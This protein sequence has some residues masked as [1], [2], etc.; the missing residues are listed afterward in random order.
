MNNLYDSVNA[1][2][3]LK[4]GCESYD[5][6]HTNRLNSHE[7]GPYHMGT[8]QWTGFYMIGTSVIRELRELRV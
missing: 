1:N 3:N 4:T 7:R 2:E 8:S 6:Y 5:L